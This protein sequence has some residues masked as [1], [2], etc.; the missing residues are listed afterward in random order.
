MWFAYP[1]TFPMVRNNCSGSKGFTSHPVA[2]ADFPSV[3][4]SPPASVVKIKIGVNL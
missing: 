4:L 1:N 2:P 3:F